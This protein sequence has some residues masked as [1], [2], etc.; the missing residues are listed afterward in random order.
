MHAKAMC[1]LLQLLLLSSKKE[2]CRSTDTHCVDVGS[3]WGAKGGGKGRVAMAY[4]QAFTTSQ[5]SM[6]TVLQSPGHPERLPW[7]H[8]QDFMTNYGQLC[9]FC[10]AFDGAFTTV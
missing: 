9:C 10:A 5:Q 1:N 6:F 8:T 2:P 7:D 4:L 3:I